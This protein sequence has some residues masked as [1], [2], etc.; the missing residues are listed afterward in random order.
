MKKTNQHSRIPSTRPVST[1][2]PA[3]F[4]AVTAKRNR[5]GEGG[6]SAV[7]GPWTRERARP[8]STYVAVKNGLEKGR[9]GGREEERGHRKGRTSNK[10]ILWSG[11]RRPLA[12]SGLGPEWKIARDAGESPAPLEI[13]SL[14]RPLSENILSFLATG[15]KARRP[16]RV[17]LNARSL[18]PSL[19]LDEYTIGD[20]H[21][22]IL[23]HRRNNRSNFVRYNSPNVGSEKSRR[24]L[25]PSPD[26]PSIPLNFI[27]RFSPLLFIGRE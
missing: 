17:S 6:K 7:D 24:S 25:F 26:F 22:S 19:S 20:L 11:R 27:H 8:S 13:S 10:V 4:L 12:A 15:Q 5:E 14:N 2:E 21:A 3:N 23:D 1:G 18:F 16:E 9:T